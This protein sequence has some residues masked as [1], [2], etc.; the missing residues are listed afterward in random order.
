MVYSCC[1]HGCSNRQGKTVDF[2]K[3]HF[4]S[5]PLKDPKRV[6]KWLLAIGRT[7]F[8]ATKFSKVCS[9]HFVYDDFK[10]NVDGLYRLDLKENVVPSVFNFTTELLAKQAKLL[11]TTNSDA[12]K[13]CELEPI[14][15]PPLRS[16]S[17]A[18]LKEIDLP[19]TSSTSSVQ[20]H[21]T[22]SKV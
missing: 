20:L 4:F 1:V 3:I 2:R 5:F 10:S 15:F 14:N 9:D 12:L 7:D 21:K 17:A 13:I 19:A 16:P 6:A 11:N 22:P 8:T 18:N